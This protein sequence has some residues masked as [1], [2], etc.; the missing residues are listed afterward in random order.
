VFKTD[1]D[2]IRKENKTVINTTKFKMKDIGQ[3]QNKRKKGQNEWR[4]GRIITQ[5]ELHKIKKC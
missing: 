2:K 3:G 4:S 5:R 1:I